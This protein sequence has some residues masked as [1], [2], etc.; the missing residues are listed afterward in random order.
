MVS[1]AEQKADVPIDSVA[2][3]VK[4]HRASG[5]CVV[6][7]HSEGLQQVTQ[8]SCFKKVKCC[9]VTPD[10]LCKSISHHH[11]ARVSL[12]TIK[13]RAHALGQ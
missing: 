1:V 4:D 11:H 10:G 6:G 5:S 8:T 9:P 13:K 7:V 3:F 2:V 12:P